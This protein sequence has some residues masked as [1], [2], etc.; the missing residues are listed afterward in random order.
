[1]AAQVVIDNPI[2][3]SPYREPTRHFRFDEEGITDEIVE[4]RR[5]SQYFVPIPPPRRRGGAQAELALE[6][7]WTQDRLKESEF[8]NEVRGRVDRWRKA[9]WPFITGV[10]RRLLEYWTDPEREKPL[11]FCQVEALETAIFLAEAAPKEQGGLYFQNEVRRLNDDANPGLLRVAHKM[12][13]GTGKTVVMG[14]LISWQTLNKAANPQDGRFTD[15][16]L[17]VSPGITIRDRLRVLLISDPSNYYRERDLVPPELRDDLGRARVI[18]TNFHVFKPREQIKA[19]RIAKAVLGSKAEATG[20]FTETPDQM[21][22]RV[23]RELGTKRNIVV[24]NDEAHH[25]YRRKATVTEDPLTG[26]KGEDKTEAARRDEEARVWISGLEAVAKKI[27]IKAVYD[28][29]ATPFFLKGSGYGEGTLFPWVVSDFSL[30]D[31]IEA[32]LVKIPRVPVE[33][34]SAQRDRLPT[35]RNLWPHIR[36]Q[37][38][39]K[40]RKGEPPVEPNLPATL[41]GALHSLYSNYE[42]AYDRWAEQPESYGQTTPPVF[43]IVCNNTTVSKMVFDFVAG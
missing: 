37:L 28:L 24:I 9:G 2:L 22:R 30:I 34:D 4:A 33:D 32:G 43:I 6:E 15:A 25:C 18:V 40:G 7:S 3:N 31:A 29:S 42:K 21:V 5:R 16:F 41:E 19:S 35:Y 17:V 20:V 36:T 1:L 12:A 39:K 11:F 14:M 8:I 26:L 23:C 10:T 13:T 27:G 38:P